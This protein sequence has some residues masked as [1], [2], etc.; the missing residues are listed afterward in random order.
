LGHETVILDGTTLF[1][2]VCE[3]I[4]HNDWNLL[5]FQKS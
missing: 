2:M 4:K 5:S 1:I 3:L